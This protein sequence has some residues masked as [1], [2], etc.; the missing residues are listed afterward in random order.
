MSRL[1]PGRPRRL[2]VVLAGALAAG[3]TLASAARP[4]SRDEP[5]PPV[6]LCGVARPVDDLLD[7]P[8]ARTPAQSQAQSSSGTV[9]Q[10]SAATTL[11]ERPPHAISATPRFVPDLLLVRFHRGTPPR[12]QAAVLAAAGVTPERRI[13]DLGVVVVRMAPDHRAAAL[14]KLR[15]SPAVAGASKDAVFEQLDTTPN[16]TDWSTQWGLRRVALPSAWDRTRGSGNVIVAVLDT[17]VDAAH[18]DLRGAILPGYNL[19][20]PAAPPIDDNGH[21]TAVAGIIAARTNNH[22][23]IAGIC[24]SCS[25]LPIKVLGADGTGDTSQVAAG[26]VRAADAG[27]RVISMSLGGPTDVPTLDSAIAYATAK[28]AILVAAA[29]NNGTSSPFYPAANPDV[30]SVAATNES[31][32]LYTWSNY[33]SWVQTAAPGCDDAPAPS[34]SYVVF[35]GTS[36]AAPVV[37]GLAALEISA[38]PAA[39]REEIINSIESSATPIGTVV[40]RGRI[41]ASAAFSLLAPAATTSILAVKGS[42]SPLIAARIYRR[43]V[44]AGLLTVAISF[45]GTRALTL[46]VRS[47]TGVLLGAVSGAGPLR[48]SRLVPA[49]SI[50]FAVSGRKAKATFSLVASSQAQSS[51]SPA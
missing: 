32:H 49:G 29:G 21:G 10:A 31:D 24:W 19:V 27:A 30:I 51:R 22:E 34:G 39:S 20:D 2:L 18:P 11:A 17:G 42:L 36:A 6:P 13:A 40:S 9:S 44:P 41:D 1:T 5:Q 37:A 38:L 33:G 15:A 50:A 3:G 46:T 47:Q 8:A 28:G 35:C 45:S 12:R 4:Q 14:A 23:G 48:L 26:I 25:I 7:C 16:D 43:I